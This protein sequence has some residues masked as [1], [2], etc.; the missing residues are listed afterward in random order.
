MCSIGKDE[1]VALYKQD[2]PLLTHPVEKGINLVDSRL[3]SLARELKEIVFTDGIEAGAGFLGVEVVMTDDE[4]FG[5]V[6]L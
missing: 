5:E 4:G 2:A 3:H 1:K 6:C